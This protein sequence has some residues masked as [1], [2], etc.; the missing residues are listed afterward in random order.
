[1]P[2]T[3]TDQATDPQ[4]KA[5]AQESAAPKEEQDSDQSVALIVGERAFATMEDVK[6]KIVNADQHISNIES[7]NASLREQVEAANAEL[8]TSRSIE[9]VLNNKDSS[10]E[11][12]LT[13]DQIDTRISDGIETSRLQQLREGNRI[14]CQDLVQAEYGDNF[15]EK[16]QEIA[17]E[18]GLS[19]EEVDTMAEGN[20]KLFNR[21]F[22]PANRAK[23]A[24]TPAHTST[25]RTSNFQETPK[26]DPYKPVMSLTSKERT[27]QYLRQLE[28]EVNK[29]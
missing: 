23:D 1:M 9:D 24:P 10:K 5:V 3:F 8:K 19:M 27:A 20:P 2:N 25:I 15:I 29:H 4:A 7:E 21:T 13:L 18:I 28:D 14:Q 17:T 11:D 12:G 26:G 16:M 22:L 6:T